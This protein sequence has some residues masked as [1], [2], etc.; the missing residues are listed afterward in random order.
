M[1]NKTFT[2][3]IRHV[4]IIVKA[5]NKFKFKNSKYFQLLKNHHAANKSFQT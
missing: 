4:K 5:H 2:M 3:N 1:A